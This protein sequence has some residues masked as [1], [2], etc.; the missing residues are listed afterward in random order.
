MRPICCRLT[1]LLL[2][3]ISFGAGAQTSVPTTGLGTCVDFIASGSTTLTGQINN[4][5]V[6]AITYGTA[7]YTDTLG[8]VIY[9]RNYSCY[10]QDLPG[11]Y[12]TVS[13]LA[14]EFGHV[15]FNYSFPKTTRQAYIDEACKM[16]GLA[17][18]NNIT[19]RNEIW[20]F[21]QNSA[22]IRLAASN[23]DQLFAVYNAGGSN[24]ASN[25]GK[26]F[27]DNNITSTTGQNYN[28]YYGEQYDDLP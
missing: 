23:P 26:A 18:I 7:S 3:L 14:H 19:A 28:D 2:V 25:V 24:V 9:I 5:T 8:K 1:L 22:D 10:S 21:S 16:E 13:A 6:Y 20:D 12:F 11:L 27:C 15:N 17:V 4:N